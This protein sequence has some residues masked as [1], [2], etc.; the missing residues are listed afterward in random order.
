MQDKR[1]YQRFR[2]DLVEING[3]MSLADKVQILDISLGGVSLKADRRLNIGKEYMIKLQEKGLSLEV[4]GTVVR[5]ELTGIEQKADGQGISI[6]TAGMMFKE[7]YAD[8]IAE[9]LKPFEQTPKRAETPY[10]ADRRLNVR[11]NITTPEHKI[12]SYPL[13]F[14]VQSVSLGGMLIHTEQ[15]VEINSM[16][17]MEL[18]L[19][20]DTSV[21]F[22][23]RVVS[24]IM[25]EHTDQ[26]L[27]KIGVE[28]TELTDEDTRQLKT[29]I[30]YLSEIEKKDKK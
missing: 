3:K 19:N 5:S 22:I 20:V 6:F 23:G 12:L 10:A 25:T 14:K 9:F 21:K 11:F 15:S 27:Y 13:Q 26:S 7:G 4:K 29:F 2:A 28:F 16:I 24:C 18:S 30:D 17:P 8:K 1:R